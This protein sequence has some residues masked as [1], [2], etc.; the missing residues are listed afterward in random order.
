M[1]TWIIGVVLV[2]AF[3]ASEAAWHVKVRAAYAR[4][5]AAYE[6]IVKAYTSGD[7]GGLMRAEAEAL[8]A[9]DKLRGLRRWYPWRRL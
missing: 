1:T 4:Q 8:A 2:A 7:V 5:R 9:A 3:V 6:G